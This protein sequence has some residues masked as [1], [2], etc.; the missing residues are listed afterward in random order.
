MGKT[1]QC[2]FF[3]L[4]YVPDAVKDEFVNIGL[5]MFEPGANGEGFA[6]VRFTRDWRRVRCL[7]PDADIEMLE[8][9]EVE[10][11]RELANTGNRAGLLKRV[12]D[13]FSN[14]LQVSAMKACVTQDPAR[15]LET[16]ARM[17]LERPQRGS[18]RAGAGRQAIVSR[19]RTAFEQA[20][21]WELM[22]KG[23]EVEQ[24]THKGDPL[25]IDCGYRP[26][27][28]IRLF[29][30]VAI[31][32][33]ADAAKVLAFSYPQIAE[34][35]RRAEKADT[36]LTAVVEEKLDRSDEAVLFALAVL[37]Q[38]RIRVAGVEEMP[39]LAERARVELRV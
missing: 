26:N 36:E 2:E 33:D 20:G 28:V 13:S 24:Y 11:G 18:R 37:E 6:G 19:M 27:G 22:R 5:V 7:D 38:N 29:H 32:T 21:V 39:A 3:L 25:K 8:A 31:A 10:I 15:E 17:Y 4:R 1:R 35:V 12:E 14:L 23:I 34:G 9:V 16:L 30:G